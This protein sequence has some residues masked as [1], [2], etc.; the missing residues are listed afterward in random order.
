[1][2]NLSTKN[3]RVY[4]TVRL[5]VLERGFALLHRQAA[6]GALTADGWGVPCPLYCWV[7]P[8]PF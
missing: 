5:T 1:M 4:C 2:E 6:R 7:Y 3:G 8:T